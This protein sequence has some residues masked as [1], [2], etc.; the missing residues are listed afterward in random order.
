[1]AKVQRS[2]R[3]FKLR[4]DFE[5]FVAARKGWQLKEEDG[6]VWAQRRFDYPRNKSAMLWVE[7]REPSLY[8]VEAHVS[9]PFSAGP[10]ESESGKLKQVA[11]WIGQKE[12]TLTAPA[13]ISETKTYEAALELASKLGAGALWTISYI[14]DFDYYQATV[15][16]L[17]Q[18]LV[19]ACAP[20]LAKKQANGRG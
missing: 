19:R 12:R 16:Q 10:E 6:R 18:Q 20:A 8:E 9:I 14:F 1:M 2:Q 5:D 3:A 15:E 13:L 7:L 11:E 4:M 17:R